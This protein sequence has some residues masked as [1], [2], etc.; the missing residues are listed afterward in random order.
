M[1]GREKNRLES[2]WKFRSTLW[3]TP[4]SGRRRERGATRPERSG[5]GGRWPEPRID[6]VTATR[7]V[8]DSERERD[9]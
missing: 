8:R 9:V 3:D 1:N 7:G 5:A 4:G 6:G 2:N